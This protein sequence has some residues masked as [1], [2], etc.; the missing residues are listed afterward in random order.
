MPIKISVLSQEEIGGEWGLGG[1]RLILASNI[2]LA[3]QLLLCS[4]HPHGCPIAHAQH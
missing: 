3:F 1:G 2:T 4:E